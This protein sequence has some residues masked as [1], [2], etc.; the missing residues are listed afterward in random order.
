MFTVVKGKD[1]E[2][3]Q[4]EL[5]KEILK[6]GIDAG[7]EYCNS[8]FND[9]DF[10]FR[11]IMKFEEATSIKV[12]DQLI[13][14]T[15]DQMKL[16]KED[17]EKRYEELLEIRKF[18]INSLSNS[19]TKHDPAYRFDYVL[20]ELKEGIE[21]FDDY[22]LIIDKTKPRKYRKS[23]SVI[24]GRLGLSTCYVHVHTIKK[25]ITI[26]TYRNVVVE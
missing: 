8:L 6:G 2:E 4:H 9:V 20:K 26:G 13:F 12:V 19:K 3:Y 5:S 14:T 22:D 21:D 10:P 17:N 15:L 16:E 1:I 25:I 18:L 24:R 7:K 23:D 11:N